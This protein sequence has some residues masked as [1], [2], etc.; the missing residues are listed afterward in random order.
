MSTMTSPRKLTLDDIADV[1]AYERERE[2]V[3]G[4]RDGTQAHDAGSTSAP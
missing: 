3:P 2:R 1:R 4:P